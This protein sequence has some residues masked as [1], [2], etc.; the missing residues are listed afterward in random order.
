MLLF[1]G[2]ADG[3]LETELL[4][5]PF[6]GLAVGLLLVEYLLPVVAGFVDGLVDVAGLEFPATERS[7]KP[8]PLVLIF[9]L[10]FFMPLLICW[11]P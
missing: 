7:P 10:F 9:G 11:L 3:L 8:V 1:A 5:F 2:L 4:A 6:A